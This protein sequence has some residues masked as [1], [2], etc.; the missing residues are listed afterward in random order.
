LGRKEGMGE[1]VSN[2]PQDA[3]IELHDW[4]APPEVYVSDETAST[5]PAPTV[6]AEPAV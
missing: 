3:D 4:Q 5:E 1:L 6:P 2:V